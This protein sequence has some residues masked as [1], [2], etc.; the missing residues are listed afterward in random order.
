MLSVASNDSQLLAVLAHGI[1]LV[2]ESSLE[3]L[4]G[5]VGELGLGDERFG[6]STHELLLEN[7]NLGRVGFLVLELSDL[8]SDLLLTCETR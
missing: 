8:I 7:D 6:L 4:S 5:D 3:L 2:S 1:E